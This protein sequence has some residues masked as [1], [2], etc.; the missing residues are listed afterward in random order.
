MDVVYK[1]GSLLA[2]QISGV[3]RI[4]LALPAALLRCAWLA[5][6]GEPWRSSGGGGG[7]VFY[8]GAVTHARKRPVANAFE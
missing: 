1:G 7:A 4:L 5:V 8:E 3:A 6:A 2:T